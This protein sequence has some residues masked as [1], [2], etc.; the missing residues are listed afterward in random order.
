M[1]RGQELEEE[2]M[3]K[4][5]WRR[6]MGVLGMILAAIESESGGALIVDTWKIR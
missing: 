6:E 3:A 4:R 5:T 2:A 1:R